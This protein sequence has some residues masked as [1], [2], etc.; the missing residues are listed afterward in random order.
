MREVRVKYLLLAYGNE[1]KWATLPQAERE[2]Y[3]QVCKVSLDLLRENGYLLANE[4][5]QGNTNV[6][7][8]WV[9]DGKLNLIDNLYAYAQKELSNLFII[10]AADL[11]EAI[12]VAANLPHVQHGPIEV[13]PI[14][15]PT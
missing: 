2:K 9:R 5:L 12:Q 1:R 15:Q 8:V 10:N 4:N 13:R 7:T 11:N 3:L 6:M 14:A